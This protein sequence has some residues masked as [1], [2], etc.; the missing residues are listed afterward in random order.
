MYNPEKI[1]KDSERK[2]LTPRDMAT[3][4]LKEKHPDKQLLGQGSGA[5]K[6]A[7]EINLAYEKA[8]KGDA[9]ELKIL[10]FGYPVERIGEDI[11]C[12][13]FLLSD[14]LLNK[15][16]A[17]SETL[18]KGKEEI[19]KKYEELCGRSKIKPDNNFLARF[20]YDQGWIDD[21]EMEKTKKGISVNV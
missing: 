4:L 2:N 21:E 17:G 14:E 1:I 5:S 20:L 19:S 15:V 6:E 11:L 3:E 9:A 7:I 12:D 10:K 16:K 13:L 8:K 18:D